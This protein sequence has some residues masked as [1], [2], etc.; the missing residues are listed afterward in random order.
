ME[1][2]ASPLKKDDGKGRAIVEGWRSG[3]HQAERRFRCF[4]GSGSNH[5]HHRQQVITAGG[6]LIR[7]RSSFG[8]SQTLNY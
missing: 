5:G 6:N 4:V 1:V 8:V 2:I 3:C 7:V